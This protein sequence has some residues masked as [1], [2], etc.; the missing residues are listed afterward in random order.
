MHD[1]KRYFFLIT[2]VYSEM[3]SYTWFQNEDEYLISSESPG[4][5][6]KNAKK[7]K[8]TLNCS[9][10]LGNAFVVIYA[11]RR[12]KDAFCLVPRQP[13]V[14]SILFILLH[15]LNCMTNDHVKSRFDEMCTKA[16]GV[17]WMNVIYEFNGMFMMFNIFFRFISEFSANDDTDN[18]YI[19]CTVCWNHSKTFSNVVIVVKEQKID[20]ASRIISRKNR[21]QTTR[22]EVKILERTL[23][24]LYFLC[25]KRSSCI[26]L[27]KKKRCPRL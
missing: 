5:R 18:P 7:R 24:I 21:T 3:P 11:I 8:F 9:R 26:L 2:T 23:M 16:N 14:S 19:K 12:N 15:L 4:K 17:D 20:R 27:R 10:A 13:S 25:W 22:R 1:W 6:L